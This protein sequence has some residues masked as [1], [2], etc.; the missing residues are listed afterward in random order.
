MGSREAFACFVPSVRWSRSG[1]VWSRTCV[2]KCSAGSIPQSH[3][4]VLSGIEK[5]IKVAMSDGIKLLEVQFPPTATAA[6]SAALNE[7]MDANRRHTRELIRGFTMEYSGRLSVAFPDKGEAALAQRSWK[8]D[9]GEDRFYIST[10][11]AAPRDPNAE[12]FFVLNPGFNVDEYINLENFD[13]EKRT[14]VVINGEL[15]RIRGGYYP[16]IFYPRLHKV[17]ERS[18]RKFVPIYFFKS[19]PNRGTLLRAYPGPWR[20]FY[21]SGQGEIFCLIESEER[22]AY[23]EIEKI[24]RKAADDERL[25]SY[26]DEM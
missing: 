22:P 21:T 1:I 25:S 4:E 12:L 11:E 2:V 10:I 26:G 20:L 13:D 15:D 6:A 23:Q 14:V 9:E 18:L 5:S 16:R 17:A 3:A 24:L 7:T 8:V 19:Y